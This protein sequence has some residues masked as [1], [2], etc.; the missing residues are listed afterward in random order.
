MEMG[1]PV[2]AIMFHPALLEH[3]PLTGG[4]GGTRLQ[5]IIDELVLAGLWNELVHEAGIAPMKRLRDVHDPEFLNE[6]HRRCLSGL[7]RLDPTTPIGEKS[8]EAA[9]YGAG[10]VIDAI[11]LVMDGQIERATC[12]TAMPGH[13]AG[14]ARFGFGSLINPA[15]VGAHFLT[16]KHRLK[17]VAIIDVDSNHG[18][19]TQEIFWKRRDVLYIS[20]HEYPGITGT[21]HYTEMGERASLGYNLN[22]PLPSGYGD[23]EY[24]TCLKELV[25]PILAQFGPEFILFSYG[26]NVLAE[27]PSSHV[28][29]SEHGLGEV[30]RLILAQARSLCG[31]RVI[32]ILEGG[33]PGP[34]MARAVAQH[35]MLFLN[36]QVGIVDKGKKGELI[37]YSDWYAYA[38]HLKAQL[39]KYWRI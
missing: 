24:Q 16:K 38:K 2:G 3:D 39:K 10:G 20:L 29:M 15:A 11:D 6:L 31:G 13:H 22:F 23:R 27:D 12:L 33:T 5:T 8:F 32:S 30:A 25:F 1:G 14:T 21:G 18:M 37:S 19:G 9:R 17:R 7:E 28:I 35:V 34:A 26:T 4:P 36:E